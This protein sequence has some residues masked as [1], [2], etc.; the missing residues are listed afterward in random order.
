MNRSENYINSKKTALIVYA[1]FFIFLI[2]V[3][4]SILF[5][6]LHW[7]K[8]FNIL[9]IS[10]IIFV[11]SGVIS[12][13]QQLKRIKKKTVEI[14][15]PKEMDKIEVPL[16]EK[17]LIFSIVDSILLIVI[18]L[19]LLAT[20]ADPQTRFFPALMKGVGGA[21]ILYFGI[22]GAYSAIK[23]LFNKTITIGLTI[24]EHGIFDNTSKQGFGLIAW[25]DIK[26][27]KMDYM[28]GESLLIIPKNP[29][30]YINKTKGFRR[31]KMK[32]DIKM[33]GT[34]PLTIGSSKLKYNLES[35]EK[36]I[37][38]KFNEYKERSA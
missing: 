21:L 32:E 34:T 24:D 20:I 16:C 5:Y 14:E 18:G 19:S 23:K 28:V 11:I 2:L 25:S 26:E 8:P 10:I 13:Y 1:I 38:D 27:M 4:I 17:W 3:V 15:I 37:D 29:E 12:T 30:K 6:L 33:Y 7:N 9:N 31:K 35:L 36:F 22:K